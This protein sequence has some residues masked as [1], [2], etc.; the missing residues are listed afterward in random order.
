MRKGNFTLIELLVVIAIIAI[1]AAMLL[2]ALSKAREKARAI[3]CVSNARQIALAINQY[4]MDNEYILPFLINGTS[5]NAGYRQDYPGLENSGLSIKF[6]W[7][8]AIFQ[9]VGDRKV[10][11]CP[12]TS[13]QLK[14]IGYGSYGNAVLGMPYVH[15]V[16]YR[17]RAPMNGHITPSQ[18]M[19]FACLSTSNFNA[20]MYAPNQRDGTAAFMNGRVN[21]R[22]NGGSNS[23]M[24]D[25]HVESHKIGY[26][27]ATTTLNLHDAPSRLWA[28]YEMGK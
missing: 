23:G 28:H 12:S 13:Y 8:G 2:P 15:G 27:N 20:Y 10:Y 16:N 24:L 22:H 25:G 4:V 5:E 9:Y 6:R 3:A 18:T 14:Q 11:L 1:L 17:K 21:D 19:Y 26:Y 7:Y